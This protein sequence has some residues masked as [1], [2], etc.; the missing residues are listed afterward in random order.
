[1]VP[2]ARTNRHDQ[3]QTFDELA[4]TLRD[5][6]QTLHEQRQTRRDDVQRLN[7]RGN[8]SA[9]LFWRQAAAAAPWASA[10]VTGKRLMK[11]S[12]VVKR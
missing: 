7:D 11:M 8:Q 1:L 5:R 2:R 3:G 4:Q 12:R 10:T 9:K 6:S